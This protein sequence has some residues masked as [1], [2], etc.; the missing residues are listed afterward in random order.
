MT[1]QKNSIFRSSRT[2]E[3]VGVRSRRLHTCLT[4][5]TMIGPCR[6]QQG[7]RSYRGLRRHSRR[8]SVRWVGSAYSDGKRCSRTYIQA[9]PVFGRSGGRPGTL[10]Y[11]RQG[12]MYP[13]A[14]I[15]NIGML[16]TFGIL[17]FVQACPLP[18][19]E[20]AFAVIA[21]GLTPTT[22]LVDMNAYLCAHGHIHEALL[23]KTAE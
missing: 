10:R 16:L 3:K 6:L 11:I 9:Q 18:P 7:T 8:T 19:P 13:P 23:R 12:C 20:Y 2:A 17:F 1:Q 4:T 22:S 21:L 5:L 14:Q 15:R